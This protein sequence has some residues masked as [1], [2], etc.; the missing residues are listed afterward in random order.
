MNNLYYQNKYL[1][2]KSKYFYIQNGGAK[3]V[4]TWADKIKEWEDGIPLKYPNENTKKFYYLT[5][6]CNKDLTNPYKDILKMLYH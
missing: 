5:S 4:F 6:L 1:K 2:Y 3:R